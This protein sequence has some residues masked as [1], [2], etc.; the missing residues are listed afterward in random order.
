[1]IRT[2]EFLVRLLIL[3]L[4]L[5]LIL[6][7][8]ISLLPMQIATGNQSRW[9]L[10]NMGFRTQQDGAFIAVEDNVKPPFYFYLN[11]DCTGW[12]S[13]LFLFALIFAVPGVMMSRRLWGLAAGIPVIWAGNIARVVAV[14]VSERVY[15]L[16]TA[17]LIHDY[18][19]Q[20][21]LIVL[22]LTIWTIWLSWVR[23]EQRKHTLLGRLKSLLLGAR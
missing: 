8:G 13:M 7:L 14:V 22:V 5:Y 6:G 9:V 17:M 18:L 12:K 3:A 15:G 23:R 11:D 16:E 1:M 21:G 2:L 19:W 10:D 20:I 4:P